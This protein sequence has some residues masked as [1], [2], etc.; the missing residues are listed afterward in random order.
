MMLI[1][2]AKVAPGA[3]AVLLLP[4]LFGFTA[5]SSPVSANSTEQLISVKFPRDCGANGAERTAPGDYKSPCI[6]HGTTVLMPLDNIGTTLA[7]A[8]YLGVSLP[9]TTA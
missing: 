5:P 7:A 4:T 1:R 6:S 3:S 2:N 9:Q 8:P